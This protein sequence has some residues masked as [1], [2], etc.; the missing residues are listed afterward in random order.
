MRRPTYMSPTDM[1]SQAGASMI[2]PAADS[3]AELI[4]QLGTVLYVGGGA[5]FV[6]V[7]ILAIWAVYGRGKAINPQRWIIG[8]GLVF[9]AVTL[10]VL[11]VYSLAVGNALTAIGTSNALQLFLE[12]F[13]V[14]S[15]S[16]S[17]RDA[18]N[19]VLRIHVI[20]KQWW[21]E[22]R[23]EQP[24]SDEHI[25]LA[26]EIRMPTQQA[27]ELVLSTSDVI[28][29]F[30]A[31]SLAGKVD[32]IPGR[33][34][35]LRLQTSEEGTFRALC[36]EYCGGQHALMALFVV[37][38]SPTEFDSWLARQREPAAPPSDPFLSLGHDAFFKGDCHTCHTVR[39]TG[40]DG[41]D[42][43]D[44]THVGGRR[45]LAAGILNNHIGTM[46]GWIA[47]PQEVKP[48]NKMP[49]TPVF[50]G[51]ELR[52]LSAWLGSLQ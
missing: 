45:S 11:L 1:E 31:P 23:Y 12:C 9:P 33:T 8:G 49:E 5:I 51:T 4:D 46:A 19:G 16:A 10:T 30:W 34:T 18:S 37:T 21:W 52:A 27:V 3:G 13:G 40:A 43:P 6:V 28:H 44:L 50:T 39:G 48:G 20:G 36:A 41:T 42:G 2:H 24:G 14:G 17:A 22:V 32:M 26:N 47:G 25:V 38:Q 15:T 35:R 7:M 29:S